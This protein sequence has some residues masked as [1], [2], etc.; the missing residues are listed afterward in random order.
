MLGLSLPSRRVGER[1]R[2]QSLPPGPMRRSKAHGHITV[3]RMGESL[4]HASV[5]ATS[6]HQGTVFP[7][8]YAERNI[9]SA[10][11]PKPIPR[12]ARTMMSRE[13]PETCRCPRCGGRAAA[14]RRPPIGQ[15]QN[16]S[17]LQSLHPCADIGG[18]G[19]IRT[20]G[21]SRLAGFQDQSFRP[22][23]HPTG[24]ALPQGSGTRAPLPG[25][26]RCKGRRA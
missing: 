3:G 19:G 2:A 10:G 14:R 20:H 11:S 13:C 1:I 18:G 23:S 16:V 5:C 26:C 8:G 24:R 15:S 9:S 17:T 12:D 7:L 6:A 4:V 25:R 22:L 21:A